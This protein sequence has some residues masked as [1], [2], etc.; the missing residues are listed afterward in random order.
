LREV[1]A[2]KAGPFKGK[3]FLGEGGKGAICRKGEGVK[4]LIIITAVVWFPFSGSVIARFAF[5]A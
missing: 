3:R 5:G 1:E 4:A 2:V